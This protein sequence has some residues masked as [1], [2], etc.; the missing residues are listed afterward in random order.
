MSILDAANRAVGALRLN[1]EHVN[2]APIGE[3]CKLITISAGTARIGE[4]QHSYL[5]KRDE[6][7]LKQWHDSV[8][9]GEGTPVLVEGS[10]EEESGG[11]KWEDV[12]EDE[13]YNFFNVLWIERSGGTCYRKSLGRMIQGAWVCSELTDIVLG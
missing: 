11:D 13:T 6:W 10:E 12:E 4:G 9:Q 7:A 8:S 2:E 1:L 5:W 3:E